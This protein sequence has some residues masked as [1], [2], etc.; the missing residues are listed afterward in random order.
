MNKQEEFYKN[1]SEILGIEHNYQTP[2]KYRNRWNTRKLGN[3]RFPGY[4]LIQC[5]GNNV[6][7]INKQGT[8][9][10]KSYEEVYA[11][12]EKSTK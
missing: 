11:L 12:L 9:W 5:F 7:V 4:G 3:G 10:F 2:V 8:F 1:C 6:R